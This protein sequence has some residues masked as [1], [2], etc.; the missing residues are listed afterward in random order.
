MHFAYGTDAAGQANITQFF[1]NPMRLASDDAQEARGPALYMFPQPIAMRYISINIS[2]QAGAPLE[3]GRL[4]VGNAF[5]PGF[6]KERGAQRTMIDSGT[7]TRL[8][9][10]GLST[11][12]GALI[13]GYKWVFGDLTD[14]EVKKLYGIVKR[15][16]TT[17]PLLIIEDATALSS[18]SVHYCTLIDLEPYLRADPSQTRWALSAE[19]WL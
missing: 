7:R 17:E 4:I 19:D 14:A 18:E 3:V 16:R 5:R 1:S 15:R 10:G 13:S 2:R 8:N 9:D 12:S 6:N 11:V